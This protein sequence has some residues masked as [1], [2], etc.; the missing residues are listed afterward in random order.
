MSIKFIRLSNVIIN[1]NKII[2]IHIE[3]A[4]YY[5]EIDR[6]RR[7]RGGLTIGELKYGNQSFIEVCQERNAKDYRTLKNWIDYD[8]LYNSM[9]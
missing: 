3:P 1:P 8:S 4:K 2:K 6:L 7:L 5:I 9:N